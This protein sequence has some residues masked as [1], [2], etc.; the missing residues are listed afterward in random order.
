MTSQDKGGKRK[1]VRTPTQL[2]R[3]RALDKS[4]QKRKRDH[5]KAYIQDLENSLRD[6]R[7]EILCLRRS[8]QAPLSQDQG[9]HGI[10]LP[11]MCHSTPGGRAEPPR[12]HS[13]ADNPTQDDFHLSSPHSQVRR[14]AIGC[15]CSP[16]IHTS[17]LQC[18][19]ET[20]FENLLRF[21]RHLAPTLAPS[22]TPELADILCLREPQNPIS[23]ILYKLCR[24]PNMQNLILQSAVYIICYRL[25]RYRLFPSLATFNDVP[26]WLRPSDVQNET[27]HPI[28]MDF[29]QFPLLRDA[30]VL[31]QI[32]I[33]SIREQ[34]DNDFGRYL[35]VNWPC[36][37]S[38]M[39]TD[40]RRNTVLNPSFE[41]HV[42]IEGNWSLSSEFATKYP[43]LAHLVTI[44]DG[45]QAP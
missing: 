43:H 34:F 33:D 3:K 38:L 13:G 22:C 45:N 41:R 26:Q 20:V 42:C 32:S 17:Y 12:V 9:L 24:R 18:F 15:Y 10:N 16:P 23:T 1:R 7:Q 29:V 19:E 14:W 11:D 6:A 4:L 35:S 31:G 30:M 5:H 2:Q 21:N 25:L 28:Y 36:S 37:H 8:N 44:R 39:V 27:P 40:D